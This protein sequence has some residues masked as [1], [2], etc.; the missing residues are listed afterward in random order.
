MSKAKFNKPNDE[1]QGASVIAGSDKLVFANDIAFDIET[2]P[3]KSDGEEASLLDPTTARVAA[4]GYYEPT[5]GRFFISYDKDEKAM[6]CQFWGV[7]IWIHAAGYKMIG[8]NCHGFDLPFII[9]RSWFHGIEVPQG[10]MTSGGRYWGETFIDLMIVWR[11]GS[12]K[13]FISLDSLARYLGVGEKTGS[14]EKF[15]RL[16]NTNRQAAVDYLVNDVRIT[17]NCADK[18]GVIAK[19][20]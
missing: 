6:L 12:W 3:L 13:E 17:L 2:A 9:R 14:G 5:K 4:I 10:V 11:C 15:Y 8:F 1:L 16:W 19:C 18:M 7:F 20:A